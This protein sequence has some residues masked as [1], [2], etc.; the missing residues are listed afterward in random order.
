[1]NRYYSCCRIS[2]EVRGLKSSKFENAALIAPSRISYEVRGLKYQIRSVASIVLAS[3]LIRG[4]WIEMI[5]VNVNLSSLDGRI[6]YEVRGLKSYIIYTCT[7]DE[8]SHLIRGAWIEI[9]N[10]LINK[11]LKD[12]ASHTRCVD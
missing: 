10:E 7:H 12:V 1:M 3:H 2:Y 9:V 4:A 5:N 6:S 8:K 11:I